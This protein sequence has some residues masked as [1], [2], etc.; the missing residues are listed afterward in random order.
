LKDTLVLW[1]GEFGR[2]PKINNLAGRDHWPQCYTLVMAGG[3][4]KGGH[5]HGASDKIGAF[6]TLGQVRPEDISATLFHMM[7]IDPENEIRDKLDRP[8]PLSRGKVIDDVLA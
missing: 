8:F 2:T 7:G 4:V 6:P 3:G 1:M 5:I